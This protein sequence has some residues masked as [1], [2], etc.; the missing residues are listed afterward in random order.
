MHPRVPQQQYM[1]RRRGN[2]DQY[3]QRVGNTYY[4]RVRVPRTLE[5]LVGQTHIR[6][7]LK[8]SSRAD[9]N[10]RKH[11][12]VSEMKAELAELRKAPPGQGEVGFTFAEA[13]AVRVQLEQLRAAGEHDTADTHELVAADRAE[14]L[15]RLAATYLSVQ[16]LSRSSPLRPTMSAL[17][18]RALLEYAR[19]V[20][21]M[22]APDREKEARLVLYD[23]K[24]LPPEDRE[25]TLD[26]LLGEYGSGGTG[27]RRFATL[28]IAHGQDLATIM[29]NAQTCISPEDVHGARRSGSE[30]QGTS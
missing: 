14:G 24:A 12:A 18:R 10:L 13:R 4:A 3:L 5:K 8:T 27:Q 1:T 22:S 19:K 21:S 26:T 30:L 2:P 11:A 23:S 29:D 7:S 20:E 28:G 16:L 17:A 9:A 25:A 15:E 6:R